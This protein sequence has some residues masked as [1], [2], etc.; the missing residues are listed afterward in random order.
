MKK[1]IIRLAQVVHKHLISKRIEN[2]KYKSSPIAG[3]EKKE[4]KQETKKKLD[5][6]SIHSFPL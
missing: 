3:Y 6:R 4:T 1:E 2:I 5:A